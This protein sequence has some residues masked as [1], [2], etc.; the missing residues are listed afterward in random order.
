MVIVLLATL[1]RLAYTHS[2]SP[3]FVHGA[4]AYGGFATGKLPKCVKVCKPDIGS[5]FTNGGVE[6]NAKAI[7]IIDDLLL[8]NHGCCEGSIATGDLPDVQIPDN[9]ELDLLFIHS[10]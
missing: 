3:F 6:F 2:L 8:T 10:I 5:S 9:I 1:I 4:L 7:F